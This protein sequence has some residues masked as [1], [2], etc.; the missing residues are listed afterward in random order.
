VNHTITISF[1][2][3]VRCC[4]VIE[5]APCAEPSEVRISDR[6]DSE[7]ESAA[8]LYACSRHV[9]LVYRPGQVVTYLH[10]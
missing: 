4:V 6:E 1:E 7:D 9:A 2:H 10:R 8:D 5:G 3:R